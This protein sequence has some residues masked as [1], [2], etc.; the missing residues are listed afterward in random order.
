M[1]QGGCLRGRSGC[2]GTGGAF[3]VGR[4]LKNNAFSALDSGYEDE[5]DEEEEAVRESVR[6]R[7]GRQAEQGR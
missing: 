6:A 1:R 3:D 7:E 5:S 2:A 4:R